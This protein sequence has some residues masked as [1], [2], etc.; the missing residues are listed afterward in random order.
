MSYVPYAGA[1]V[2]ARHAARTTAV[3][4]ALALALLALVLVA[5]LAA[6]HP[7]LNKQ[8]LVAPN[9]GGVL[10]LDL[11]ASIS[12]DTFSRIGQTLTDIASRG[13]RYGLVVFSSSAYEALPPGTPASALRPLIRYFRLPANV[14]P[15]EQP[16]YP[17]N[18]WTNSFTAGTQ[19][20]RGLDLAR[21]IELQNHAKHP[22]VVLI[23][24]LQD[25]PN[26]LDR[27]SQVLLG[28]KAEKIS[29]TVIPLNAA[30]NDLDRYVGIATR[31]IP[32]ELPGQNPSAGRP[33]QAS[34]P[35]WLVVLVIVVAA[36]LGANE[37]RSARLRWGAAEAPA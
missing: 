12:S 4:L 34:F 29:L 1:Q 11:S 13:G 2:F 26:D 17:V 32:A 7:H 9:A 10:V 19:I 22:A 25:D 5:A 28:Y 36:L 3:R 31:I 33:P 35:T 27:L 16:T 30:Q 6:R 18:P 14:P 23:S 20:A 24:D 15:G 37:L 21:T 8:P